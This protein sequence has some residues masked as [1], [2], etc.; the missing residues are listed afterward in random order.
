MTPEL[1]AAAELMPWVAVLGALAMALG[2][3]ALVAAR[4]R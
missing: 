4:R 3:A 2:L 1:G